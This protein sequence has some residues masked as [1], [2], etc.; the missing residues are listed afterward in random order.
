MYFIL[1][2]FKNLYSAGKLFF[3]KKGM[4][5]A[6]SSSFY[7]LITV[8]PFVLLMIRGIGFF[9]GNLARTQKYLFVL[10]ARF[11]PE[12][13]PDLLIKLQAMIKGP[14]FAESHFTLLNFFFLAVSTITF[15]NSIWMGVYFITEDKKVL[16]MWRILKGFAIIGLT[17]LMIGLIFILPPIIIYL[18]KILQNNVLVQFL[19][20]N[21]DFARPLLST[22]M[23]I[24]IKKS[25]WL[26]S[27]ILHLSVILVYF[28]ILYR[29]LFN[30][31]IS[32]KESF[33]ASLAFSVSMFIGKY[34]F[35]L[36]LTFVRSGLIRNY[37]DFY[38]SVVG[39]IWLFYLMCFFFYG[40]CVCSIY[41]DKRDAIGA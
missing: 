39:V 28:S 3:N 20:D 12:I 19:W 17:L 14:L 18:L 29:W 38:T 36:Y 4:T 1:D 40:A 31:K 22:I 30:F 6:S 41:K 37:G 23:K 26:N 34:A 27:D 25:Y 13:A 2:S 15:I 24:N 10:G 35:W 33:V 21:F 9:L 5:L 16:S 11:F 32:W 7:A 8:V